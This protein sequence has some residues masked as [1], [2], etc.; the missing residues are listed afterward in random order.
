MQIPDK[1][2]P[3]RLIIQ[4]TAHKSY[5]KRDVQSPRHGAVNI[6][7]LNATVKPNHRNNNQTI[8][9]ER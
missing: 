5:L 7:L 1:K 9:K 4:N 2:K 3:K 6:E 8:Y